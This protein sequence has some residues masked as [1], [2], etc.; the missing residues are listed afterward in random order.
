MTTANFRVEAPRCCAVCIHLDDDYGEVD[1]HGCK[2]HPAFL[3]GRIAADFDEVS[4]FF[5]VC[6]DFEGEPNKRESVLDGM[7]RYTYGQDEGEMPE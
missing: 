4:A 7:K 5:L 3:I 2:L 6:D 1:P